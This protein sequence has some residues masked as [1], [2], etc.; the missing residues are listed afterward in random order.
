MVDRLVKRRYNRHKKKE[1]ARRS[2]NVRTHAEMQK[3][4]E[5][6]DTKR[7]RRLGLS[8]TRLGVTNSGRYPSRELFLVTARLYLEYTKAVTQSLWEDEHA[9]SSWPVMWLIDKSVDGTVGQVQ[10]CL[11]C[12]TSSVI[13]CGISLVLSRYRHRTL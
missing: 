13:K 4:L 8:V 6:R 9:G 7:V 5:P 11:F 10:N 1:K 2:S 12:Q 3:G